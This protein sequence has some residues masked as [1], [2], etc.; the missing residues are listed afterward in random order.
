MQS[1]YFNI[2]PA[3]FGKKTAATQASIGSQA[4]FMVDLGPSIE[5]S[6]SH[7]RKLI[8][9]KNNAFLQILDNPVFND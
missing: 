5:F 2:G 8:C 9:F 7:S 1:P 4:S 3:V 6:K